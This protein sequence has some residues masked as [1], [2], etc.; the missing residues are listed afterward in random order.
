MPGAAEDAPAVGQRWDPDTYAHNARFVAELGLPVLALLAPRPGERILD[1]GCGD[2]ALTERLNE[3]GA[4][5]VGVDAS[6]AQIAAARARCAPPLDV[7]VVDGHALAFDGTFDAVFSNAALHWMTRPEAVIGG[8]W[9][10]LRA[11]GRFVGEMGGVGNVA[12]ITEALIAALDARGIDG[13]AANPWYFP[14]SAAYGA[15]LAARGFQVRHIR[16]FARPTPLPGGFGGWLETFAGDFLSRVPVG[17]RAAVVAE[18][19]AALAPKLCDS[20]GRW[21]AD[22]VRLRFAVDKPA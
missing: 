12:Y 2:G 16:L 10:A 9:R 6:A 20:Q 14:S 21:T 1:L 19:T 3:T 17:E 22:Y 4:R 11:G 7:R 8:V 15:L 5:V 13:A 18:V